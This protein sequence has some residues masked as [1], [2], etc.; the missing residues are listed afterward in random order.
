MAAIGFERQI[1]AI[2]A[3]NFAAV[4]KCLFKLFRQE[5]KLC[6]KILIHRHSFLLQQAVNELF[7]EFFYNIADNF[8]HAVKTEIIR[9]T[10][11]NCHHFGIMK[12]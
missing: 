12:V 6:L 9:V 1:F 7:K 11:V 3:L 10:I 4:S 5:P 2:L 8:S